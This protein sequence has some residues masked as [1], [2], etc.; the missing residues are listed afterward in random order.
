MKVQVKDY[1]I[2]SPHQMESDNCGKQGRTA[3]ENL[4]KQLFDRLVEFR[5]QRKSDNSPE[6]R[7]KSSTSTIEDSLELSAPSQPKID[8]ISLKINSLDRFNNL[9]LV[10][11]DEFFFV[12]RKE[13]CEGDSISV[14][15][16]IN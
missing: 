2:S 11:L 1:R 3:L 5:N 9:V 8:L 16:A 15:F 12:E 10:D 7:E 14:F 13:F 6:Q 4:K